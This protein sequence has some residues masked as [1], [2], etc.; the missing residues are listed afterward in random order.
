M[1][2]ILWS[3]IGLGWSVASVVMLLSGRPFTDWGLGMAI[4][5]LALLN[6]R[7]EVVD[8]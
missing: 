1:L 3:V 2:R 5:F 4:S 7:N 8:E 6:L